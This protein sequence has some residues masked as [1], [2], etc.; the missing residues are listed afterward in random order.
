METHWAVGWA[1]IVWG[2]LFAIMVGFEIYTL[3]WNKK[4]PGKRANLTA[5]VSAFFRAG[6]RRL[7]YSVGPA[8]LIALF[9]YFLGHFLEWWR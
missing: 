3:Y 1:M 7:K 5:Y 4:N 6:K 9:L 8:I 2:A